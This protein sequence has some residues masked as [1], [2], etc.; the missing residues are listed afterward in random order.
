[1]GPRAGLDGRK[2]SSPQG[3]FPYLNP[4][5][6]IPLRSNEMRSLQFL[7]IFS[8]HS[9]ICEL[10]Y[11][12]T[13]SWGMVVRPTVS[14]DHQVS[15]DPVPLPPFLSLSFHIRTLSPAIALGTMPTTMD[16]LWGL[17]ITDSIPDRPA[18]S[19]SLY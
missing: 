18:R 1:M 9:V 2:I 3:F 10:H 7:I 15:T 13:L 6:Y 8:P 4:L 17:G 5:S 14:Q 11:N 12:T 16:L 19:Q